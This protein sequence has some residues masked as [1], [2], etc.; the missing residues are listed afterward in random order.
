MSS[1]DRGSN[2]KIRRPKLSLQDVGTLRDFISRIEQGIYIVT[3]DGRIV[4]ANPALLKIFGA[5]SVEQ[6]QQYRSDELVV[7]PEV[8][9]DRRQML[10][11]HG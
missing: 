4:D 1:A 5:E 8:R 10:A 11:E 7:D 2:V 9:A 3:P 6:L